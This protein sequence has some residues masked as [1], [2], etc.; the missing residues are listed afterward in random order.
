V[1][2][3]WVLSDAPLPA[4]ELAQRATPE[5]GPTLIVPAATLGGGDLRPL[6]ELARGTGDD[7]IRQGDRGSISVVHFGRAGGP[8]RVVPL[9][10]WVLVVA[11][12]EAS[13]RLAERLLAGELAGVKLPGAPIAPG[14]HCAPG[15]F[16]D[17][18]AVVRGPVFL[19]RGCRVEAGATAGPGALLGEG[20]VLEPG[21]VVERARVEAGVVVGRNQIVRDALVRP[22]NIVP[23]LRD[24]PGAP[25][26]ALSAGP[27]DRL[28]RQGA[29][30]ALLALSP[31]ARVFGGRLA[32]A[33][34]TLRAVV[35]GEGSW[36]GVADP[37]GPPV[38]VDLLPELLPPLASDAERTQA[39]ASYRSQKSA[40]RDAELVVRAALRV[41]A[42][43][44]RGPGRVG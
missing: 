27:D 21:A 33:A 1:S 31:V 4:E 16:V 11:S 40:S 18:G 29:I 32:T 35:A 10:G 19:G 22:G 8:V 20:V 2:V 12:E 23:H 6:I 17:P 42:R 37:A 24:S 3:L 28:A 15:A 13:Q 44:A 43:V 7:A 26:P 30:V 25:P 5:D 38:L 14:V 9:P 41:V 39:R 34:A 36:V